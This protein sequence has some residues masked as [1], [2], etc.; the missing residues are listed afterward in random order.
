MHRANSS[1]VVVALSC[2]DI[3]RFTRD[4]NSK[5]ELRW[6]LYT[7]DNG[8]FR[9]WDKHRQQRSPIMPIP[10]RAWLR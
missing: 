7:A 1:E 8:F 2:F 4:A 9:L 10:V 3:V 5:G 6:T